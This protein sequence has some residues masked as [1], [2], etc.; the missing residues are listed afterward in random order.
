[1]ISLAKEAVIKSGGWIIDFKVFS[2]ISICLN[3]ELPDRNIDQ[4][5][6]TLRSIGLRLSQESEDLLSNWYHRQ[7]K[8]NT[9]PKAVDV[10]GT[11]QITFVHNEPDLRIKVPA[12]PG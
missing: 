7:E 8:P 6:S 12:I 4:L 1:M 2:N 3:F 5:Y 11:L 9:E 10:A